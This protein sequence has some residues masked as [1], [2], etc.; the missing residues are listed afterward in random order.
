MSRARNTRV[1][2][3]AAG[4]SEVI[5]KRKADSDVVDGTATKDGKVIA[6]THAVVSADGQ[7]FRLTISRT[8]ARG[9]KVE[10]VE[11]VN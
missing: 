5:A 9:K 7:S 3:S 4:V 6:T 2:R 1:V 11:A 8:D 10:S